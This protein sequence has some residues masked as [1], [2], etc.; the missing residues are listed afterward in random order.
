MKYLMMGF[1][2]QLDKG[3]G[4][5]AEAFRSAGDHLF[6]NEEYNNQ[7]SPQ[8]HM[9]VF[10]LY[11]HS[12]ELYF[13]SMIYLFH[14]ELSLPYGENSNGKAQIQ[15]E[16]RKWRD[17]DN[18]HY[19]DALF[20]YWSKLIVDNTDELR[21][22]AP[23]GDWR[24]HPDLSDLVDSIVK[25][26]KDSTYFRYPFVKK[27]NLKKEGEKYSM[28]KVIDTE[29]MFKKA[30]SGKGG[31]TM[32]LKDENENIKSLYTYDEDVLGELLGEFKEIADILHNYHIMTRITLCE[33]F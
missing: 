27:G 15:M 33:G 6:V 3:F 7:F 28:K 26:D 10:Y 22:R 2:G 29:E 25:Y 32:I 4:I 24:V 14:L 18:C 31:F 17:M 12:I 30:A 9:P 23:E 11:R 8:K 19:I 21:N 13:K 5:N 16:N 1:E 20:W